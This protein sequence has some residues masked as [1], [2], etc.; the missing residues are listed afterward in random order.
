MA[1][2]MCIF[3]MLFVS[4]AAS[5]SV[6]YFT[7]ADADYIQRV[8][9]ILDS[10]VE[11]SDFPATYLFPQNHRALDSAMKDI[12]SSSVPM[13]RNSEILNTLIGLPARLKLKG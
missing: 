7:A 13:K 6:S 8:Q 3:M 11:S 1:K 10:H 5:R 12:I 4:Y 2:V 9:E